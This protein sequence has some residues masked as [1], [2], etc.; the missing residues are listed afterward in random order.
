MK[1]I[2]I[3]FFL[4]FHIL[5]F[6]TSM[7][8]NHIQHDTFFNFNPEL[9]KLDFKN[10]DQETAIICGILSELSYL[11]R[12]EGQKIIDNLQQKF[13]HINIKYEFIEIE[14]SSTELIFFGTQDYMVIAFRGTEMH[15]IKD[16]VMDAKFK[17]EEKADSKYQETLHLPSGHTGFR[18]GIFNL[19][20]EQFIFNKINSFIQSIQHK[21]PV[22]TFPIY[23]TGH[24][25][26]AGLASLLIQPLIHYNYHFSGAYLFAPPLAISK[27]DAKILQ[28]KHGEIIHEIVNYRDYVA[29]A[30]RYH[31]K[32]LAHIGTFYRIHKNGKIHQEKEKFINLR[33]REK[34]RVIEFHRL[35]NHI[36]HLK[37]EINCTI[38]VEKRS[39][40]KRKKQKRPK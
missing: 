32:K 18:R 24:S 30:T 11:N 3:I 17:I 13:P 19:L 36:I 21:F 31:R 27:K 8:K 35:I 20:E 16:L 28:K 1:I 34:H 25:L 33:K 40:R 37:K 5:S 2:N 38:C 26:G 6:T 23:L 15:K 7:G 12:T 9:F 4:L 29:R 10:Y 39:H 14:K 22:S